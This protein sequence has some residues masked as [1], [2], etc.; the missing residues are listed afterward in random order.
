MARP[1]AASSVAGIPGPV[2]QHARLRRVITGALQIHRP[3]VGPA[4]AREDRRL[5]ES[6]A[7]RDARLERPEVVAEQ[8]HEVGQVRM[9]IRTEQLVGGHRAYDDRLVGGG[10]AQLVKRGPDLIDHRVELVARFHRPVRLASAQVDADCTTPVVGQADGAGGAH[11]QLPVLPGLTG[12]P[13]EDVAAQPHLGGQD[14]RRNTS[15]TGPGSRDG[16]P[17]A[18]ITPVAPHPD[19]FEHSGEERGT[20]GEGGVA[21]RRQHHDGGVGAGLVEHAPDRAVGRGVDVAHGRLEFGR[22]ILDGDRMAMRRPDIGE[23]PELMPNAVHLD[24]PEHGEVPRFAAEQRLHY[25]GAQL[26]A[27][28][29]VARELGV[30]V[31]SG[32]VTDVAVRNGVWRILRAEFIEDGR[33]HRGTRP[34]HVVAAPVG[35]VNPVRLRIGAALGDIE[36]EDAPT[37]RAGDVPHVETGVDLVGLN[38]PDIGLAGAELQRYVEARVAADRPPRRQLDP[39]RAGQVIERVAQC[40]GSGR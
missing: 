15:R 6:D 22:R 31:G 33:G 27:G 13:R 38:G 24:E 18:G 40:D 17:A 2:I 28:D 37:G 34:R 3:T 10:I 23:Q 39:D 26:D 11:H 19:A 21:V 14:A 36:R 30:L 35:D 8:H 4:L 32:S 29:E 25:F 5:D 16:R 20:L 1:S 12:L 9:M 7:R